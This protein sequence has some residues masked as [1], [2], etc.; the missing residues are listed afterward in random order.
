[1]S[2]LGRKEG[3]WNAISNAR[4]YSRGKDGSFARQKVKSGGKWLRGSKEERKEDSW[5]ME[6]GYRRAKIVKNRKLDVFPTYQKRYRAWRYD[7]LKKK[8]QNGENKKKK[9]RESKDWREE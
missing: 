5:K 9:T 8:K 7:S 1:M 3:E 6:D 4:S 2:F